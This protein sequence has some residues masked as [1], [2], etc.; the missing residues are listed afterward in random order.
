MKYCPS[1]IQA[2]EVRHPT[3]FR[4]FLNVLF[5]LILC[6]AVLSLQIPSGL[7]GNRGQTAARWSIHSLLFG[8]L[9][10]TPDEQIRAS[11]KRNLAAHQHGCGVLWVQGK[12]GPNWGPQW[13]APKVT[14]EHV[15]ACPWWPLLP[16]L[17]KGISAD[18]QNF[19]LLYDTL[20]K[21][22]INLER[23]EGACTSVEHRVE[24]WTCV[25]SWH[26]HV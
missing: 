24:L 14:R 26:V 25:S 20:T 12:G 23:R 18:F 16:A 9:L 1:G 3:Y 13:Q 7:T 22:F 11:R 10:Y 17:C 2:A 4:D 19:S 5:S 15:P 6:S 21:S 8:P